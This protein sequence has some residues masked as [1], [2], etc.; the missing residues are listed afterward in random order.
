MTTDDEAGSGQG[1]GL[2]SL[3]PSEQEEISAAAEPFSA[4][5]GTV[6]VRQDEPASRMFLISDGRVR[7]RIDRAGGEYLFETDLG[8]GEAVGGSGR[9]D[10]PV[11][12]GTV[13]VVEDAAG[14][15]V[16]I[17]RLQELRR[18]FSPTAFKLL[19]HLS[20]GLCITVRHLNDE[21]S[22]GGNG[23][24]GEER[25]PRPQASGAPSADL[26]ALLHK[27]PFFEA[28]TKTELAELSATLR[29]WN[30]PKGGVLF[31][32]NDPGTSCFIAVKGKVDVSVERD[33]KRHHL[34]QLG[35]GRIFGEISLLDRGPRSA[36][37]TAAAD[38]TLVELRSD[39]F[40]RLFN[41]GS[42]LSFKF[43]EAVHYN[44]L[45]AQAATLAQRAGQSMA[46]TASVPDWI[47]V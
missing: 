15:T 38:T 24:G 13:T 19:R 1:Y 22:G 41:A 35:P 16:D 44:L 31:L 33:G 30:V 39:D 25:G 7:L 32:Q 47:L 10:S 3:S 34:A 11:N 18:D 46:A 45:A 4:P 40:H 26:L 6:L 43:L 14:L 21:V 2:F 17:S 8:A 5:A 9:G 20:R 37:C 27:M 23:G 28:F 36:T 42:R 29:Q 12:L